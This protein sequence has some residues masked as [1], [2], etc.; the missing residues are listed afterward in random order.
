MSENKPWPGVLLLRYCVIMRLLLG[1]VI[2][3]IHVGIYHH[4]SNNIIIIFIETAG[5]ST[6]NCF[7]YTHLKRDITIPRFSQGVSHELIHVLVPL[8]TMDSQLA[9]PQHLYKERPISYKVPRT[10]RNYSKCR[11]ALFNLCQTNPRNSETFHAPFPFV[12]AIMCKKC[13]NL[14]LF[15]G[16]VHSLILIRGKSDKNVGTGSG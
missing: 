6:N 14:D 11:S 3:D 4:C 5:T 12:T 1:A 8:L 13:E 9:R 15:E 2:K 10:A 16:Y 7:F